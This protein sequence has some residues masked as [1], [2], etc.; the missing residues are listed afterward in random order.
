MFNANDCRKA[1]NDYLTK[2]SEAAKEEAKD[3]CESKTSEI[4]EAASLGFPSIEIRK[5]HGSVEVV[6]F[7]KRILEEAGFKVSES[8]RSLWYLH[9]EW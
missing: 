9:I 7:A 8:A 5:P 3:Y 2:R 1:A 6:N 4:Y